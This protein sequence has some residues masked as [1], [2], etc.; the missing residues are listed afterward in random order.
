MAPDD[1]FYRAKITQRTDFAPDLWSVRVE[2][3][4]EFCFRPGQ[5]AT[6]GVRGADRRSERAY[7]IV[8][9]PHE[10]EIEF[11]F[12][13]VPDGELTPQLHALQS[14]DEI[15]MRKVA[16]GRFL[17]DT[18]GPRKNH[19]L[20]STVTGIAPFISY[21]RSLDKDSRD[22]TFPEGHRVF[23]LTG[24]SRSWELAYH[25]EVARLA[26]EANWLT[27]VAT[28]S[29]PWEDE[30]W[31]GETGRVDDVL[32]K[33]T[34][35]GLTGEDTLAYLCGHP[36]MIEQSKSILQRKGLP[37]EAIKEEVYWIP[38]KSA[39]RGSTKAG[40]RRAPSRLG[41]E[42]YE[43]I[44]DTNVQLFRLSVLIQT[45]RLKV[46]FLPRSPIFS[47][48]YAQKARTEALLTRY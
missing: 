29:R 26:S 20:V 42:S 31:N 14:G 39:P 43:S 7:S 16:K 48:I 19:L 13:L 6:L 35:R 44:A 11:F 30:K 4:G 5:Y 38:A 37:K 28:I 15:L 27:Y 32:R 2:P 10:K 22:G 23:L 17:L 41:S 3:G 25:D 47:M 45:S 24:G 33:Y 12:E 36:Q 46:R 9:S 1:K 40:D 21:I 34:D 18:N 8:S